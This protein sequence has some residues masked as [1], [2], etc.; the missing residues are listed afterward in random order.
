M[1]ISFGDRVP[2]TNVGRATQQGRT[3][4][5]ITV[6]SDPLRRNMISPKSPPP[7]T[8]H[9]T[10][11]HPTPRG[12]KRYNNSWILFEMLN[13][14]KYLLA[15]L[16]AK[17]RVSNCFPYNNVIRR[18]FNERRKILSDGRFKFHFLISYISFP[19]L[20]SGPSEFWRRLLYK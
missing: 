3:E 18:C 10:P 19:A 20:N 2:K 13:F 16:P 14:I 17:A 4:N 6:R 1:G 5:D 11:P 9:P 12:A 15:V 7:P 8:P